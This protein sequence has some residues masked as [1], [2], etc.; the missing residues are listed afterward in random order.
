M[1]QLKFKKHRTQFKAFTLTEVLLYIAIVSIVLT[2]IVSFY[3]VVMSSDDR[4]QTVSALD[5]NGLQIVE[6]ITTSIRNA[7]SITSPIPGET[8]PSINLETNDAARNP[9]VIELNDGVIRVSEAGVNY[10]L[11]SNYISVSDLVFKN[12]TPTDAN[13]SIKFQFKLTYVNPDNRK[14]LDYSQIF[15]G[16][17]TLR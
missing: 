14:S 6:Y 7:N 17:A 12:L 5:Q 2:S 16:S 9:T 15:Y 8:S 13:S 3:A 10:D 11:S 1:I 4:N